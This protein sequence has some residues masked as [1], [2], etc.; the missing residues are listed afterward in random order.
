MISGVFGRTD[1]SYEEAA[2]I[3]GASAWD[4][5]RRVS[6]PLLAPA[7]LGATIYYTNLTMETFE[8]PAMLGLPRQIFVFSTLIFAVS[9][10]TGG[11]EMRLPD[12]GL[13]STYGMV[14]LVI[15][16]LLIYIYGNYVRRTERF[17]TVTGRGYRPR[18]I[19][20]GRWKFIPVLAM[21]LY[22]IFAVGIPILSLLWTSL[23]PRF[24]EFSISTL[25]LLNLN[26]YRQMLESTYLRTALINTLVVAT[27]TALATMFLVTLVAWLSVRG[28]SRGIWAIPDRL[29]FI[30]LGV[31]GVVLCLS[32]MFIYASLP[33][34]IYGSIWLIIIAL[35]TVSSTY[36]TRLM[37]AAFLQIHR[38]LEEAAGTSG[39][40]LQSTFFRIVLPLLWPSF[41]RGFLWVLVH[42]VC[43]TTI[44]LILY[45]VGN[46]VI[47]VALWNAWVEDLNFPLASAIA[48]PLVIITSIL[49]FL[50]AKQT[51]LK[52]RSF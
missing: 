39:A 23:A 14:L 46:Q 36:G 22:F 32:L 1:P 13:A 31:P 43:S 15:S 25:S 10:G 42:S 41:G 37:S 47:A 4:S 35:V 48:V 19:D 2:R 51:M 16:I 7:I 6:L 38:E 28:N 12:Y 40:N 11:G 21:C 34:P 33:I 24:A 18:L 30:I 5:F 49:A 3:S 26:A 8:I 45:S 52:E 29:S 44:P 9:R 20:L 17:A 27:C 50:L